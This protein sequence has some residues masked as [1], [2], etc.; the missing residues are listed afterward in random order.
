MT[1]PQTTKVRFCDDGGHVIFCPGCDSTHRLHP[2]VWTYNGD[3]ESP[4][5]APSLLF[6]SGHYVSG[7][8]GKLCWCTYEERFPGKKLPKGAEI[9][10]CKDVNG[11][12]WHG[13]YMGT[14][15]LFPSPYVKIVE[16]TG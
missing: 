14:Q 5:F 3:A 16:R 9:K 2:G 8:A 10:E 13:T 7:E 4:T 15:G 11:D 1:D 6:T 12:W